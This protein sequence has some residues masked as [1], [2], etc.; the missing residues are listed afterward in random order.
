M[1]YKKVTVGYVIQDYI[2]LEDNSIV[3]EKQEF[4]AGDQIDYEDEDGQFL[5]VDTTKE[6]YYQ[7]DMVQPELQK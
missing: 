4:I 5:D 1:Y 2:I 6:V 7:F 3:C